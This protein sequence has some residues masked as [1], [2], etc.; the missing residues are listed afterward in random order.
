MRRFE[1]AGA[2]GGM[3]E[4]ELFGKSNFESV[5]KISSQERYIPYNFGFRI[6]KDLQ[7]FDSVEPDPDF[8]NTVHYYVYESLKLSA[9]DVHFYT[10]V[11]SP[12]D[13]FHGVDGWFEI[14]NIRITIDLCTWE[15]EEYKAEIIFHVPKGGLDRK[16]DKTQFLDYSQDLAAEVVRLFNKKGIT[17][18][19]NDR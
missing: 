1:G 4:E 17:A 7:P 15:K 10:A 18:N 11:K 13:Y 6:L 16:V 5:E 14:G 8:A 19:G 12:L 3:V 9:E 2:T